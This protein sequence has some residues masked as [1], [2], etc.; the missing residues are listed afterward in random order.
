[1]REKQWNFYE[2]LTEVELE[3]NDV[4]LNYGVTVVTVYLQI[5]KVIDEEAT[6]LP[7]CSVSSATS[8][9]PPGGF[10]KCQAIEP[11]HLWP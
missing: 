7:F 5:T 10:I 4:D 9:N 3:L 11:P 6:E 2:Y 8:T 1:M